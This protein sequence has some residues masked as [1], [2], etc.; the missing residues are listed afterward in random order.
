LNSA[1]VGRLSL[2]RGDL[3]AFPG[4]ASLP[5]AAVVVP[6]STAVVV[7]II[8]V[9][10]VVVAAAIVVIV[11]V[12]VTVVVPATAVVSTTV[13]AVAIAVVVPA[14]TVVSTAVV[15]IAIAV[16]V[17][18]ATVISTPV[19]ATS[20]QQLLA[21]VIIK[22]GSS[23]SVVSENLS[24][25]LLGSPAIRACGADRG[26]GLN[27]AKTVPAAMTAAVVANLASDI[28]QVA[29]LLASAVCRFAISVGPT[30]LVNKN[31][32]FTLAEAIFDG[33]SCRSSNSNSF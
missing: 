26:G 15:A 18:A 4:G 33:Q 30:I 24:L 9:V 28:L 5:P 21:P 1:F 13:V 25:E 8:V 2:G 3:G 20:I 27:S 31:L 23:A 19:V 12:S 10:A 11:V 22:F 16:V 7:V 17:P 14:A 29:P 32:A 6:A